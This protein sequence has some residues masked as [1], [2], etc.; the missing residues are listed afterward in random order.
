MEEVVFIWGW[1]RCRASYKNFFRLHKSSLP[2]ITEGCR[3]GGGM[4][5]GYSSKRGDEVTL[6]KET[7]EI[8]KHI[9]AKEIIKHFIKSKGSLDSL[10]IPTFDNKK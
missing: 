4:G 2:I 6:G 7:K 3:E 9:Y 8:H 10:N 1:A 5:Y